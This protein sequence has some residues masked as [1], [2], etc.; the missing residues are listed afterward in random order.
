VSKGKHV[1]SKDPRKAIIIAKLKQE[2]GGTKV[3]LVQ[4][5]SGDGPHAS[6]LTFEGHCQA[7]HVSG[8]WVSLGFY[9]VHFEINRD[10]SMGQHIFGGKVPDTAKVSRN[11]ID[12]MYDRQEHRDE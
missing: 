5:T 9:F 7:H 8:S 3:T 11:E 2:S 10:G 1:H 4:Q 12:A 6:V